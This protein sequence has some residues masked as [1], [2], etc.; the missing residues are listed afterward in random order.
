MS[1]SPGHQFCRPRLFEFWVT[2]IA[3]EHRSHQSTI[4]APSPAVVPENEPEPST[5][6]LPV[7]SITFQEAVASTSVDANKV[8]NALKILSP[9]LDALNKRPTARKKN[10]QKRDF[11]IITL[12]KRVNKEGSR[13]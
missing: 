8:N 9:L 12:Q 13:P 1:G 5:S 6:A 2:D 11:D 10:S 4:Q 7:A 3:A